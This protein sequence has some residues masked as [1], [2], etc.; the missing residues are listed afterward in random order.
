MQ[1]RPLVVLLGNSLLM[2]GVALSLSSGQKLGV[3]RMDAGADGI[4][5]QLKLLEPDLIVFELDAPC[6][7]K[8]M[9]LIKN[10]PSTLLLGLDLDCCRAIVLNS[11]QHPTH[12]MDELLRVVEDAIGPKSLIP[13]EG[14]DLVHNDVAA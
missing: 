9:S 11:S 14:E 7:P 10:R 12:S 5:E 2:D 8:I 4:R 1:N 6:S 13:G 3:V